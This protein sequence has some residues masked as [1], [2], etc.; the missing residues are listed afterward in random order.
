MFLLSACCLR[1]R[2]VPSWAV[3][4]SWVPIYKLTLP[5]QLPDL[6][7]HQAPALVAPVHT[8]K[9]LF[10][11]LPQNLP[12]HGEQ[13]TVSNTWKKLN[14]HLPAQL[15]YLTNS[16]ALELGGTPS[17]HLLGPSPFLCDP[18]N[19]VSPP[20]CLLP[21]I[22]LV[23][24]IGQVLFFPFSNVYGKHLMPGVFAG[25]KASLLPFLSSFC[26]FS[27]LSLLP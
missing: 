13:A 22:V 2:F 15:F 27:A 3:S 7:F 21:S 18:T 17:P 14:S 12:L 9:P 26:G 5:I 10:S 25:Q 20:L 8:S 4:I 23:I 1:F 11:L 19:N 6:T 16:S 24:L